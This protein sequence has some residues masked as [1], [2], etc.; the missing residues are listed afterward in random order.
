MKKFVVCLIILGVSLGVFARTKLTTLPERNKIRI[1]MRNPKYSLIEEE[2]TINLQKG[3]NQVEFAWANTYIDMKTIQFRPIKAP[4]E[5]RVLNVNYPPNESALF[6]KTYSS[7]AGPGVFR[8]SYIISN[9]NRQ[10]AYEAI[11]D[12]KEKNL[13]IK[14]YFLLKNHLKY[15]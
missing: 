9:L 5:I 6:W 1:D 4:G 2:R 8:I 7:K 11:A 14:T 13:Y 15:I 12:N 10:I 3:V